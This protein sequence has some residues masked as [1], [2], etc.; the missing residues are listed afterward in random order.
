MLA[1]LRRRL[2]YRKRRAQN[3]RDTPREKEELEQLQAE[4][5]YA[6]GVFEKRGYPDCWGDWQRASDDAA[7]DLMHRLGRGGGS[8]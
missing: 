7:A 3:A 2:A 4:C 6:E 1:T 8:W 5:K